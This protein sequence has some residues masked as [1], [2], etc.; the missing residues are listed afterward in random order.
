M[1]N[2]LVDVLMTGSDLGANSNFF[3]ATGEEL[4]STSISFSFDALDD[5]LV[6]GF[7][8]GIFPTIEIKSFRDHVQRKTG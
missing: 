2:F 7:I 1:K 5:F 6:F 8:G 4:S 3:A